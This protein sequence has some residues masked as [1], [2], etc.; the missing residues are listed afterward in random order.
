MNLPMTSSLLSSVVCIGLDAE[1]LNLVTDAVRR[2]APSARVRSSSQLDDD[3]GGDGQDTM[4]LVILADPAP[5]AVAQAQAA[6]DRAALPRWAV[7]VLGSGADG[8]DVPRV[9]REEWNNPARLAAAFE[10]AVTQH[11]LRRENAR[12]RGDLATLGSRIAHDFRTPLGG[13][14]TTTEMLREILLETDPRNAAQTQP[15]MESAEGLA[16]LVERVSFF[17][18]AVAS[19]EPRQRVDMGTPFWNAFQ[20]L[21]SRILN[22]GATLVHPEN[23]PSVAGHPAWL[24]AI[25]RELLSNAIQHGG[26]AVRIQAGWTREDGR[27]RFWLCDS[28]GVR[29]ERRAALFHPFHRLNEPGAPRGIG[30]AIVQRLV[31][32]ESGSCGFEAPPEG[33]SCFHFTLPATDLEPSAAR[34]G[35]DGRA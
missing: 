25:W 24:Q 7:A 35:A 3:P 17:A 27:H 14:L 30:L 2:I 11:R 29:P 23:W 12:L 4:G 6:V 22:S 8:L 33:G 10:S 5:A 16:K 19:R 21:E 34:V 9:P 15:I 18:K 32:L 13:V 20:Q 28:G 1:G 31:E 26:P